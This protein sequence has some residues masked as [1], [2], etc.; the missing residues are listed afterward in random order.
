MVVIHEN[1]VP[2]STRARGWSTILSGM[3][4]TLLPNQKIW[5]LMLVAVFF[6]DAMSGLMGRAL[7]CWMIV[8]GSIPA[9]FIAKRLKGADCCNALL[10]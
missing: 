4:F 1:V 2:V 8:R 3:S 7:D 9:V 10:R 6:T 5:H